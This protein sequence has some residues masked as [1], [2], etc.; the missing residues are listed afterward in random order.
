MDIYTRC[1]YLGAA[2]GALVCVLRRVVGSVSSGAV[3][4]VNKNENGP[5]NQR[6][7][8]PKS[9]KNRPQIDEKSILG[10]SGRS[11]SLRGCSGAPPERLGNA[12]KRT[13]DRQERSRG[14]PGASKSAPGTL[15]ASPERFQKA[16]RTPVEGVRCAARGR[17][18]SWIEILAFSARCA[19]ARIC[20]SYHSCQCFVDVGRCSPRATSSC[21]KRRKNEPGSVREAARAS[22][23]EAGRA[24]SS[25]KTRQDRAKVRA[26]GPA[27]NFLS[28]RTQSER[29]A[30]RNAAQRGAQAGRSPEPKYEN[31]RKDIY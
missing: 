31:L 29:R 23:I 6:K 24:R 13:R 4:R 10:G 28:V 15:R 25:E 2:R 26:S 11:G 17:K 7:I 30:G 12:N 16:P 27:H 14:R 3:Q 9:T 19:E 20:V 1:T 22:K 21:E 5:E 8:I 18:R